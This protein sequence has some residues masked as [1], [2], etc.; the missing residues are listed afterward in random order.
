MSRA[1]E[2]SSAGA[3]ADDAVLECGVC[4]WVYDPELG[5]EVWDI[6][7]KT[8][9][10]ALP[11]HWRCPS[12]DADKSKFMLVTEGAGCKPP[13]EETMDDRVSSM[14]AAFETAEAAM[15]GLPVHNPKMRIE[16]VGFRPS[17]DGYVGVMVTP[18]SM[19][20]VW[21]PT[22]GATPPAAALGASREHVFPSGGYD[23]LI[24]R[25]DGVGT[26]ETCSLFSPMDEFDDPDIAR[27]C[28]E[29]ALDGLF[30]TPEPPPKPEAPKMSRRF[31]LT[32]NGEAQ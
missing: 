32:L 4:W 24:G 28:A 17:N 25:M 26:L 15:L 14:V 3:L 18:W 20:L 8:A 9:F 29:A 1:F 16:A 27:M 6:P 31:L 11:S 30:E 19:I 5:D 12:C 21:L 7:P 10:N 22:S 2:S 13:R 23:F